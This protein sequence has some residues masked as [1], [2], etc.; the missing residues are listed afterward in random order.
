MGRER[1]PQLAKVCDY[2]REEFV[3]PKPVQRFCNAVCRLAFVGKI[4]QLG[5]CPHCGKRLLDG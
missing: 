4:R 5:E 2:C 3:T 1:K